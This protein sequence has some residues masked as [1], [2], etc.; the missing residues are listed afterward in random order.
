[1]YSA[2]ET[3]GAI[4]WYPNIQDAMYHGLITNVDPHEYNSTWPHRVVLI[5]NQPKRQKM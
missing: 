4:Y 2:K 1:M 3:F 5:V